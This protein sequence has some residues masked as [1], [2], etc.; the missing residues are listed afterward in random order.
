M[1]ACSRHSWSAFSSSEAH[2]S[3]NPLI[4]NSYTTKKEQTEECVD[5]FHSQH[6]HYNC[7]PIC[8]FIDLDR[9]FYCALIQPHPTKFSTLDSDFDATNNFRGWDA[10]CIRNRPED[11][12][13]DGDLVHIPLLFIRVVVPMYHHVCIHSHH[14]CVCLSAW[15]S[16]WMVF[17]INIMWAY[18]VDKTQYRPDSI[19]GSG[20]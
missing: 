19:E 8:F 18:S 2:S 10:F 16:H 17:R 11:T 20:R 3:A 12:S 1:P 4:S 7:Q 13:F 6:P 9:L 14:H 5:V 15:L